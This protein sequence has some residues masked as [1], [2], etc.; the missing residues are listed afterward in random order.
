MAKLQAD[1]A[2]CFRRDDYADGLMIW[3]DEQRGLGERMIVA[4]DGRVLCMGYATFRGRDDEEFARGRERLAEAVSRPAS[5]VRLRDVQHLLCELVETLD[6]RR[7]RYTED[8][9]RA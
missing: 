6:S 8:L 7:M 3:S 5:G 4:D 1:I 9:E 2:E